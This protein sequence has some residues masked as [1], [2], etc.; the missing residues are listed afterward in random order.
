MHT[1]QRI[2]LVESHMTGNNIEFFSG[3]KDYNYCTVE[4][5]KSGGMMVWLTLAD[6]RFLVLW[7]SDVPR[8]RDVVP[9]QVVYNRLA[10]KHF[11]AWV[12]G[13][14]WERERE[15]EKGGGGGWVGVKKNSITAS[16]SLSKSIYMYMYMYMELLP[17][18]D[19][20]HDAVI[21]VDEH[22]QWLQLQ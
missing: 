21:T 8:P 15:R 9:I 6:L 5:G 20:C 13:H 4:S 16:G 12:S 19:M 14:I 22:E 3:E 10:A 7:L 1:F 2:W 18:K 17:A 11:T